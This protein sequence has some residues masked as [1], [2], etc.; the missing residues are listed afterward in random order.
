MAY[1]VP[2]Q[3]KHGDIPTAALMNKYADAQNALATMAVAGRANA[4][5]AAG[6]GVGALWT[7]IHVHRYL[8]FDGTGEVRDPDNADNA[9]TLSDPPA[10]WGRYDLH[11]VNWLYPGKLYIVAGASGCLEAWW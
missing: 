7:Y 3:W 5:G 6:R 4:A 10:G 2:P 8:Y 9:V 1:A 11:S